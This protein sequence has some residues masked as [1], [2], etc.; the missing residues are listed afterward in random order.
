MEKAQ[1]FPFEST[2]PVQP[3]STGAAEQYLAEGARD[4]A[5]FPVLDHH[6]FYESELCKITAHTFIRYYTL[7][8]H[9][10]SD[11]ILRVGD[12]WTT[13]G[14]FTKKD[15]YPLTPEL[16][17]FVIFSSKNGR[18]GNLSIVRH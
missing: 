16:R 1:V 2:I 3:C 9:G 15:K 7:S 13:H 5:Y 6:S 18:P 17:V 12:C 10:L 14:C 11:S 8:D 4:L